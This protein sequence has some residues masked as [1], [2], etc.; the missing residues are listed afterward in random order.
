MSH[1]VSEDTNLPAPDERIYREDSNHSDAGKKF[2]EPF[3][4][5]ERL[6]K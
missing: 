5:A 6:T 4:S 2:V 3:S 1:R